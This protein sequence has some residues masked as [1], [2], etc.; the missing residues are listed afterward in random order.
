MNNIASLGAIDY[1]NPDLNIM[2]LVILT[3]KK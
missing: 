1:T 2:H 3:F